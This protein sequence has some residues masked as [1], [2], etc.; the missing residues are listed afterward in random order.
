MRSRLTTGLGCSGFSVFGDDTRVRGL[1]KRPRPGPEPVITAA[2]AWRI[3]F[4]EMVHN[5]NAEIHHVQ[6]WIRSH[7]KSVGEVEIA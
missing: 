1:D 5:P 6:G 7:H 4:A 2:L 3:S